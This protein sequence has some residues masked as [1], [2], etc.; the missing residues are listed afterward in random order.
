MFIIFLLPSSVE[1]LDVG[2]VFPTSKGLLVCSRCQVRTFHNFLF[3]DDGS[4]DLRSA[5][6]SDHQTPAAAEQVHAGIPPRLL[7]DDQ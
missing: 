6:L 2:S 7:S 4:S 1:L 3:D 5:G